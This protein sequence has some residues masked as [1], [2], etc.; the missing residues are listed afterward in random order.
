MKHTLYLLVIGISLGFLM[1]ACHSSKKQ[2]ARK[3]LSRV[4]SMQIAADIESL[5]AEQQKCWNNRDL[6]CFL[7]YYADEPYSCIVG[8]EGPI[9]GRDSIASIY[10]KAYPPEKM[11]KLKFSNLDIHPL[12]NRLAIVRGKYTLDHEDVFFQSG[13]YTLVLE[14]FKESWMIISD[15]TG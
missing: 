2:V 11:G 14:K 5:L 8:N 3:E 13:W 10:K 12:S 9:C 7:A 1:N 4:D 15:H 6:D